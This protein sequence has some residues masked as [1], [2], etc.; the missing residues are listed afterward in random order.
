MV[1]LSCLVHISCLSG[2]D[3]FCAV[4]VSFISRVSVV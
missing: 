3:V 2:V 1:H 4:V